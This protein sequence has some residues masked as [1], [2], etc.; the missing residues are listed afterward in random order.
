MAVKNGLAFELVD[1]SDE[2]II[3]IDRIL[4]KL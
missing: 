1:T 3:K 2:G 4:K